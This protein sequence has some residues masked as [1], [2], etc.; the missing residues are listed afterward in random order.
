MACVVNLVGRV[1]PNVESDLLAGVEDGFVHF[2]EIGVGGQLLLA[3][4][5]RHKLI[6]KLD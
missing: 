1:V 4:D 3:V 6:Y 5:C 2:L